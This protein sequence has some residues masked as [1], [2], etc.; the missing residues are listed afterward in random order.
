MHNTLRVGALSYNQWVNVR[1]DA[2]ILNTASGFSRRCVMFVSEEMEGILPQ[3]KQYTG[4]DQNQSAAAAKTT[5][6]I[7]PTGLNCNR[8]SVEDIKDIEKFRLGVW[9]AK[10]SVVLMGGIISIMAVMFAYVAYSTNSLPDAGALLSVFG[11][12]KDIV[13]VV[14][15]TGK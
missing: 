3:T 13:T 8:M 6:L 11:Q 9:I 14:M 12:L 2:K 4:E 10:T 5:T 15:S 7:D 1:A